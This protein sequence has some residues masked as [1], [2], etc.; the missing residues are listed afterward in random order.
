MHAGTGFQPPLGFLD[1]TKNLQYYIAHLAKF[2]IR[3][4][5]TNNDISLQSD[6]FCV[7]IV[8]IA[9]NYRV[10][11]PLAHQKNLGCPPPELTL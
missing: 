3:R 9:A 5:N 4:N 7:N 8:R 1:I 10:S 2:P 6:N 11:H